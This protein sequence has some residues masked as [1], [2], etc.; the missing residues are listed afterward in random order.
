MGTNPGWMSDELPDPADPEQSGS[1]AWTAYRDQFTSYSHGARTNRLSYQSARIISLTA[2]AA[3]TVSA[4]LSAT[5]W[6]TAS[7]GALIVVLEGLQQ[8]FQW[9]ENWIA[10]R[11]ATETMRQHAIDFA[12][13]V[14]PYDSADGRDRLARLALLRR[15][16]ALRESGGWAGRMRSAGQGSGPVGA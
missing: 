13:G 11:Q 4:G 14:A 5:P 12:A 9:H 16:V 6:V 15:D 1:A 2:A 7:L 8:L 10:Y 3:V